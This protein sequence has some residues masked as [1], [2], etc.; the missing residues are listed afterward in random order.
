MISGKNLINYQKTEKDIS[1]V[2]GQWFIL[3]N[4]CFTLF[5]WFFNTNA[6]YTIIVL[7]ASRYPK[8]TGKIILKSHSY[9]CPIIRDTDVE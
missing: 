7:T 2:R 8:C 6:F 3:G 5:Q 4:V 1:F 9:N